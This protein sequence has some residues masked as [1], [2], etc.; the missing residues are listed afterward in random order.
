MRLLIGVR[1]DVDQHL[2]PAD[3][4]RFSV[5]PEIHTQSL[6]FFIIFSPPCIE[7]PPFASAALPVT[8]VPRILFRFHVKV[9]DVIHQVLQGVEEKM[10]LERKQAPVTHLISQ[11]PKIRFLYSC[12]TTVPSSSGR[13]AV[14]QLTD[15]ERLACRSFGQQTWR[16]GGEGPPQRQLAQ[17]TG[18]PVR[19]ENSDGQIETGAT[20][21]AFKFS[22][23]ALV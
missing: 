12:G 23:D 2:V 6:I 11:D 16:M 20:M 5:A 9:V 19:C 22:N 13:P 8:A 4:Q 14:H 10:T 7:A 15:R 21:L 3:A 17:R 1:A 18:R